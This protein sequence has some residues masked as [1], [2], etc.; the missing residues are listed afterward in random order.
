[1][2]PNTRFWI[3]GFMFLAFMA[4]FLAWLYVEIGHMYAAGFVLGMLAGNST[5]GTL[6][7]LHRIAYRNEKA[8]PNR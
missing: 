4:T 2:T 8:T 3:L 5:D 1:M 6:R 7:S